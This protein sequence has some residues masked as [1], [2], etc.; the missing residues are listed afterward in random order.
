MEKFA[1]G[2]NVILDIE[3]GRR[4]GESV[5]PKCHHLPHSPSFKELEFRLRNRHQD[6]EEM[7]AA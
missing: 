7:I 1:S 2:L 4:P 5:C 6:S 3:A